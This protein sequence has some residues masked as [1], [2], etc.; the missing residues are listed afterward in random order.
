MAPSAAE[1]S[2]LK[3]EGNTFFKAGDYQAA[4]DAYTG[5]LELDPTQHL[6]F[7]NRARRT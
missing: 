4:I 5:S 6:C 7:S 3:D 1:A 2:R